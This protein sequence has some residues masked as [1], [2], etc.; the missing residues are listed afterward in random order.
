VN[1]EGGYSPIY[2]HEGAAST[3][4][5]AVEI[6]I[7]FLAAMP[8]PPVKTAFDAREVMRLMDK[9]YGLNITPDSAIAKSKAGADNSKGCN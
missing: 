3:R 2:S 7:R 1:P 9:Q 4:Y 8:A 6:E 5:N